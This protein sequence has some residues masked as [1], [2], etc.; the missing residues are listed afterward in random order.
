MRYTRRSLEV[1]MP[2]T[3]RTFANTL[4]ALAARNVQALERRARAAASLAETYPANE[5]AFRAIESAALRQLFRI[6]AGV[7]QMERE[8]GTV[9]RGIG[10]SVRFAWQIIVVVPKQ[11]RKT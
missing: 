11:E 1:E 10:P 2:R 3:C 4:T 9:V 5:S 6:M 8:S 7:P